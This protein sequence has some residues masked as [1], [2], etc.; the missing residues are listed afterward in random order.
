MM[1]SDKNGLIVAR[2][3]R[4]HRDMASRNAPNEQEATMNHTPDLNLMCLCYLSN[5]HVIT[6]VHVPHYNLSLQ[7]LYV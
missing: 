1:N 7:Y 4:K 5:R 6:A 2:G 3:M